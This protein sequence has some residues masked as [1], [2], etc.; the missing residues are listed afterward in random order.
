MTMTLNELDNKALKL[1]NMG[2]SVIPSGAGSSG[3]APAVSWKEYQS[4]RPTFEEFNKWAE[5]LK[6][7]LWGIVTGEISGIDV[8]DADTNELF[9]TLQKEGLKA[10]VMTPRGGAHFYFKHTKPIETKAGLLPSIDIRGDGGFVNVIGTNGKGAYRVIEHPKKN[11]N[12]W[13]KVPQWLSDAL[14]KIEPTVANQTTANQPGWVSSL[15]ASGSIEGSRNADAIRLAGYFRN[16][17]PMDIT[18]GILNQWNSHNSPAL[19]D[20]EIQTVIASAYKLAE[21]KNTTVPGEGRGTGG[22]GGGYIKDDFSNYAQIDTETIQQRDI[23]ILDSTNRYTAIQSVTNGNKSNVIRNFVIDTGGNWFTY[24]DLDRELKIVS[25]E[26]KLL[27]RAVLARLVES[28]FIEKHPEKLHTFR[29]LKKDTRRII[30]KSASDV[31][32]VKLW[33]PFNLNQLV[34]I[35]TGNIIVF[36]GDPNAGKTAL[37]MNIA[38]MNRD[39]FKENYISTEMFD[40]E[41]SIRTGNHEEMTIDEWN[42]IYFNNPE[43]PVFADAIDPEKFNLNFLDY[44]EIDTDVFKVA[45][46]IKEI[47]LKHGKGVTFIGLQKKRG[48]DLGRGAEFSLEKPRLYLSLSPG[49][50]KIIKAKNW[51]HKDLNPNDLECTYKLI[52]GAKIVDVSKWYDTDGRFIDLPQD[53]EEASDDSDKLPF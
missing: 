7:H 40:D 31:Q 39:A 13:D 45:G 32:P 16:V 14:K 30:I 8:L 15:L 28:K 37:M 34:N 27:R 17:V 42:K 41:L 52:G 38:K 2:F 1:L 46:H 5:E 51:K 24:G 22:V 53:T 12:S 26:D 43:S 21:H 29:Y 49:K 44:M 6:P 48:A 47:F 20:R 33:L 35:Y 50:C 19:P 4:R 36:A 18:T 23:A 9:E 3:K 11:L 25:S 10:H